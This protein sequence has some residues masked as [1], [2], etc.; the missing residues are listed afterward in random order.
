[1]SLQPEESELLRN[2]YREVGET[3]VI[4]KA[5]AVTVASHSSSIADLKAAGPVSV[6]RT[7]VAIAL[8]LSGLG[9]GGLGAAEPGWAASILRSFGG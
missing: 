1:M 2:I 8:G 3:K 6:L 7:K 5:L 9:A 4:V